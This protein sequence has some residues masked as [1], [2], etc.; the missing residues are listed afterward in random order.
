VLGDV[1]DHRGR[2]VLDVGC[3]FA[4]YHG[5]LRERY[6]H[7][8]YVGLDLSP[9]MAEEARRLRAG[10]DIRVGNVLDAP[11]EGRF[12]I[13][14]A[15]GI[16]YLLDGDAGQTLRE[17]VS[18]M[19]QLAE[20]AVAFNSLSSWAPAQ[21]PGEFYADPLE[22]IDFCRSLT[23]WVVLRHDYL[24]HDFTVYLYRQQGLR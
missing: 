18:R 6:G 3:G 22:I 2:R 17:L 15:N 24:P 4:D 23:P 1:A 21:E 19:F 7:V 20:V 13:V 9:R 14:T 16:F 5:Y 8:E 11:L 12:D 10:L